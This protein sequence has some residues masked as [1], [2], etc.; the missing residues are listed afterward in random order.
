LPSIASLVKPIS[1]FNC[2]SC[3]CFSQAMVQRHFTELPQLAVWQTG[4]LADS[5]NEAA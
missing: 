3:F 1:G 2:C 5:V 4:S